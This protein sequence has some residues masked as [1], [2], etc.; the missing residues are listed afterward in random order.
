VGD[1]ID[2]RLLDLSI[3]RSDIDPQLEHQ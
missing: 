1:L 2:L 3:G